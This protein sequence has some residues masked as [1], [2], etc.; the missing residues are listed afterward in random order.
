[1]NAATLTEWFAANHPTITP[2]IERWANSLIAHEPHELAHALNT[3]AQPEPPRP[4]EISAAIRAARTDVDRTAARARSD[5]ALAELRKQ[6]PK[7]TTADRAARFDELRANR[8][9]PVAPKRKAS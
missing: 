7:R 1:M 3:W 2:D 9:A 4:A 8:P 5:A 6:W